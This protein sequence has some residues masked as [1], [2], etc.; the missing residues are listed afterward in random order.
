[1]SRLSNDLNDLTGARPIALM[2]DDHRGDSWRDLATAE[3]SR[4]FGYN[5]IDRN[6]GG[7]EEVIIGVGNGQFYLDVG[8]GGRSSPGPRS[9]HVCIP[10]LYHRSSC[11]AFRRRQREALKTISGR[12][13]RV[14][15]SIAYTSPGS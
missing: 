6:D 8:D 7:V 11:W 1:M 14:F 9:I 4:P 13:A 5:G 2:T 3:R 12:A 10:D 15:P